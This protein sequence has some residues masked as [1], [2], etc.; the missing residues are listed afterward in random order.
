MIQAKD[1]LYFINE[2]LIKTVYKKNGK[3]FVRLTT[4]ETQEI[5]ETTY[6]NLGEKLERLK[7][8]E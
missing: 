7:E 4:D 6:I 8:N 2:K 3:F 5:D 1:R